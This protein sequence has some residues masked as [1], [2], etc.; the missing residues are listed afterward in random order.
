M[1][2]RAVIHRAIRV[3]TEDTFTSLHPGRYASM[4]DIQIGL[5]IFEPLV[6][7]DRSLRL[8]GRLAESWACSPDG[9]GYRFVLR[10]GAR[11]HD[12]EPVTA[13]AVRDFLVDSCLERLGVRPLVASVEALGSREVEVRL[14]RPFSPLL[15]RLASPAAGVCTVGA[16]DGELPAG[17]GAFGRPRRVDRCVHVDALGAQAVSSATFVP[18]V[19][20]ID[21]WR[22]LVEDRIDLAYECP[23][24][25]VARGAADP[26]VV[27]TSCPSLAVNMLLFNVRSGPL[28]APA[29]RRAIASA[30]DKHQLLTDVNRGVGEAAQGP[31]APSSPF[32]LP[33]S[34]V[35]RPERGAAPAELAVVATVGF[36]PRWLE[37]FKSQLERVGTRCVVRQLPFPALLRALRHRSFEAALIGFPGFVDPDRVLFEVFHSEG[38]ANYSG[39]SDPAFDDLV[40]RAR[41]SRAAEERAELYAGACAVLE[42]LAPAVFLRHG[43][44]IIARRSRLTGIEPHPLGA[45]DLAKA[46]W[47]SEGAVP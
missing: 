5:Q 3:A 34:P 29:A 20:G 12:G 16:R 24:E 36:T 6:G 47:Q 10:P 7:Y 32:F 25:V 33:R 21:M 13:T 37:L 11:F 42:D 46:G 38:P 27:V 18:H 41:W 28:A 8:E 44:S 39:L 43:V 2:E 14:H 26:S 4:T 17:T 22:A 1:A 19:G 23:Y 30:I 40:D 31:I 35:P 9:L 15:D 45:I